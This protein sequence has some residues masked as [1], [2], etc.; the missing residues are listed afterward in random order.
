MEALQVSVVSNHDEQKLVPSLQSGSSVVFVQ[1][2]QRGKEVMEA[3]ARAKVR[4]QL[5]CQVVVV[6]GRET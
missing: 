6:C 1:N 3:L 5:L 2:A 4:V